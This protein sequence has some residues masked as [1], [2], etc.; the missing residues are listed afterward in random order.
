M[1]Q[2]YSI[3][4]PVAQNAIPLVFDSP[5]SGT[6]FPADFVCSAS[7]E[8]LKTGWDA[9]VDELWEGALINGAV[10]QRAHYSRMFID[11][12]RA[13]DDIDPALLGSPS[14]ECKPTRYS[15][16]GM[17]LIRRFALP[18]IALYAQPLKMDDIKARIRDYYLPYHN[19]LSNKLNNLHERFGRVWHVDCHSMKSKGN[20]MNIDNGEPRPDVILGDND[21]HA[22]DPK[23]VQTV[24]DAFTRLG[25]KVARNTPYKG[26]YLVTHYAKPSAGRY[27][28][29]IEINRA[30][31]MDEQQY[32]RNNNFTS[33]RQDLDS[34][35]NAMASYIREQLQL[36]KQ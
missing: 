17:G 23:F 4:E 27:S 15:E 16:R 33:V 6:K 20:E 8:Q 36:D 2:T 32:T 28:M 31:Y 22:C 1:I 12:N 25:Y 11:L 3:K 34:L 19:A 14:D 30:L 9:F 26:G 13:S 21:G 29:Q 24:E 18:G 7:I 35:A 5:H 10:L